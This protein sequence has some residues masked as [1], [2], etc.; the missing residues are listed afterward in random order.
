VTGWQWASE[1]GNSDADVPPE[2]LF[3]NKLDGHYAIFDEVTGALEKELPSAYTTSNSTFTAG[4]IDRDGRADLVVW[5]HL[6]VVPRFFRAYHWNGSDYVPLISHSDSVSSFN[7]EP[8]RTA[9]VPEIWETSDVANTVS[10]D[11]RLRDLAGNVLFRASTNVLGWSGPFR[12]V[13]WV[14]L[15]HDG[16]SEMVLEDQT[17]IRKY[18]QYIGSFTVAWTLAGW[19]VSADLGNV[20]ADAQ[21]EFLVTNNADGHYAIVDQLTGAIQQELPVFPFAFAD[22]SSQD[23]DGD[24]RLE[25]V[26]R[27]YSPGQAP[28]ITIYNWNGTSLVPLVTVAGH[29]PQSSLSLVQLRSGTQSEILDLS[30]YDVVLRDLTGA[31]LF[32]ASTNIPGWSVTPYTLRFDIQDPR[33]VGNPDLILY[34]DTHVWDVRYGGSFAQA[35]VANGWQYVSNLGNTDADPQS[36]FMMSGG[37][38]GRFAIF[39]GSTGAKQQEFTPYTRDHSPGALS[40]DIDA[41][42]L[43]ELFFS[44]NPGEPPLFTAYHWNGSTYAVLY[45]HTQPTGQWGPVQLRSASQFEFLENDDTDIRVRDL[46]GTV[47]FRASTD[48]PGWPGLPNSY[49]AQAVNYPFGMRGLFVFDDAQTR[50]V[51]YHNTTAVSDPSRP[52]AL[53]VFQNAPNPFRTTTAF[54]IANPK[55]GDVGIRIFDAG[56]RLIRTLDQKLP[57]GLSEIRWDGR[58]DRARSAPSGV[59]FYEVTAGGVRQTRKLIR[60]Q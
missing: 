19:S 21:S 23:I 52:T 8:F 14:D 39:D 45:S 59:L 13:T 54:R 18:N 32:R 29:D 57:A 34:D 26:L 50:L 2:I 1:I 16:I 49:A 33:H 28:L 5:S 60:M 11:L 55:E 58:D 25:L 47:I 35:W 27:R 40:L 30:P 53:R 4:D 36:E 24:G 10:C 42:G 51:L 43:P 15:N 20:D 12:Q 37:G 46:T 6:D 38:D 56:G 22:W 44:R 7:V 48:L 17:T 31:Q 3:V 9:G 41:D